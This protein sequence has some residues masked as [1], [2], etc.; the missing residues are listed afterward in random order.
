M[1]SRGKFIGGINV[2]VSMDTKKLNRNIKSARKS[3]VRFVKGV[4]KAGAAIGVLAVAAGAGIFVKL[5][6]D[7]FGAVDSLAKVSDK[8]GIS[9]EALAGLRLASEETG[10]SATVLDKALV[11]LVKTTSEANQGVGLGVRAYKMLGIN[12][13]ALNKL[14]A[15]KQFL[16]V[17][18]AVAKLNNKQDQLAVTTQL[19]GTRGAA[20]INTLRLGKTGLNEAATAAKN[21][22]IAI[23]RESARGVERAIDAFGRLK[24]AIGGIATQVAIGIAP[25]LED[26][27]KRLTEF[28][29]S[30]GKAKLVGEA[31]GEAFDNLSESVKGL[32]ETFTNLSKDLAPL[33][34]M[35]GSLGELTK[36]IALPRLP[37]KDSGRS[38]GD[39][40]NR[41]PLSEIYRGWK[42]SDMQGT[43][44]PPRVSAE[45]DIGPRRTAA[46]PNNR[47]FQTRESIAGHQVK[48]ATA[49]AREYGPILGKALLD[50]AFEM[51]R[52]GEKNK[53]FAVGA[54]DKIRDVVGGS[55]G[56]FRSGALAA[57][58]KAQIGL[59]GLKRKALL[60]ARLPD[61]GGSQRGSL[62]FTRAGSAESFRQRARM[63]N[64]SDEMKLSK[65]RNKEL[66]LIKEKLAA[67]VVLQPANL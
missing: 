40:N 13:E 50:K 49:M 11:N 12:V 63:R 35:V 6:R 15:D 7:A 25:A 58:A 51:Y 26:M 2:G 24:L 31:I 29:T 47:Q 22:G 34:Q 65:A 64:Q 42:L 23:S 38:L 46:G 36:L 67:P 21:L 57:A 30:G 14:S 5:T 60:S 32:G 48:Q 20:L 4:A 19:L 3:L 16:K 9:T 8:I 33:V 61:Q 18:E 45:T 44:W 28:L 41:G 17:A 39:K 55:V 10:A 43:G 54:I 56:K 27:N 66:V 53:G 37:S 52:T 1:A 59:L 62:Q